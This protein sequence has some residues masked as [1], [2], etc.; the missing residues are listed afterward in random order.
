MSK[1]RHKNIVLSDTTIIQLLMAGQKVDDNLKAMTVLSPVSLPDGFKCVGMFPDYS[2]RA[3]VVTVEHES[4]DEVPDCSPA[5]EM[6]VTIRSVKV[7]LN[8]TPLGEEILLD[9]VLKRLS[10]LCAKIEH[11]PAS[12][13]QTDLSILASGIAHDIQQQVYP[14]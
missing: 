12:P 4:F 14:Q 11:L 5:P 1:V 2:R 6:E 3:C 13:E 7:N 9:S 10:E 8:N